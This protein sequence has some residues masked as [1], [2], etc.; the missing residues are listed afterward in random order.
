MVAAGDEIFGECPQCGAPVIEGKNSY[1]CSTWT[2]GDKNSCD[3]ALW[4]D[5]LNKLCKSTITSEEARSL[6]AG[7]EIVLKGLMSK[8]WKEFDCK[9]RM[10]RRNGD[11]PW[12]V[13][14]IFP[15]GKRGGYRER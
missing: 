12:G 10:E 6:L 7:E 5:N 11:G 9:G 1:Y 3:F 2:P 13:K 14:L 15:D 4:K 8:D